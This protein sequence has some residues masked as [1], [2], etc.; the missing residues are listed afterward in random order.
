MERKDLMV[1]VVVLP[2]GQ[3]STGEAA[4]AEGG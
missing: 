2:M 1:T 4:K 3:E